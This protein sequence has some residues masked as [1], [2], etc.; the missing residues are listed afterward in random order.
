MITKKI[1]KL[2]IIGLAILS[3]SACSDTNSTNKNIDNKSTVD[4]V[5]EEQIKN[6][7]S[8]S[9]NNDSTKRDLN[10]DKQVTILP[11]IDNSKVAYDNIDIDLT[12]MS[13]EMVYATVFQLVSEP[14]NYVGKVVK[15]GGEY[16]TMTNQAGD[17]HYHYVIIADATECC[18]QGIEFVWEDGSRIY[19]DEYPEEG[20]EVEVVGIF[21]EYIDPDDGLPY[22]RLKESSMKIID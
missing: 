4:K 14:K 8:A 5:L 16:T 9:S 10:S 11:I 20:T 7:D 2:A 12:V 22:C 21:E 3:L 17:K 1:C 6:N 19:P 18:V 13:S 15:M